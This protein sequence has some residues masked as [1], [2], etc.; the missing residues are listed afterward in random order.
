MRNGANSSV[1]KRRKKADVDAWVRQWRASG[2]SIS[3]FCGE[4]NISPSSMYQWAAQR[5]GT[6]ATTKVQVPIDKGDTPTF[7][8]V[9]VTGHATPDRESALTIVTAN[10]Y[11]ISIGRDGVDEDV[12]RTIL[13]VASTC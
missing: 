1:E 7:T 10:G 11:Q 12:L 9:S 6:D 2:Q 5:R 4:H 3:E 8:E 13:L